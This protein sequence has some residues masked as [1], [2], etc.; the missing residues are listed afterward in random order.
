MEITIDS[1]LVDYI[2]NIVVRRI[3]AGVSPFRCTNAD[4]IKLAALK[5][6]IAQACLRPFTEHSG[7]PDINPRAPAGLNV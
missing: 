4:G 3:G 6:R 2:T 1:Y 7:P 5:L